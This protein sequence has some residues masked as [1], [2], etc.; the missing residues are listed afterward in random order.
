MVI[1]FLSDIVI[2]MKPTERNRWA[3]LIT[4][5]RQH[6]LIN[7]MLITSKAMIHQFVQIGP[8]CQDTFDRLP[9]GGQGR[10]WID[11]CDKVDEAA[12][13]AIFIFNMIEPGWDE[14]V[15]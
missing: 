13:L 5:R 9:R 7:Q 2:Q 11:H 14:V 3:I 8:L 12:L 10:G 6:I 15:G 1:T 4:T